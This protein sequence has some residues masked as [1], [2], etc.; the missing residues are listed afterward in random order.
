MRAVFQNSGIIADERW[1]GGSGSKA[2]AAGMRR[3][4]LQGCI[5]A[6]FA[7]EPPSLSSAP[8]KSDVVCT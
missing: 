1:E 8:F 4:R 6:V 5:Y 7:I 2:F 3:T